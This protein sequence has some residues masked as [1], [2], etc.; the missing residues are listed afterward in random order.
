L[1]N[2]GG[3]T[4]TFALGKNSAP[5]EEIPLPD[6]VDQQGNPIKTDQH[7]RLRGRFGACSIGAFE[8][9]ALPPAGGPGGVEPPPDIVKQ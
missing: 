2:N 3:P 9:D 1:K 5:I 8:F 7:G 6:C 4:P